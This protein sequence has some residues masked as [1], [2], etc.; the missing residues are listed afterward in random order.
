MFTFWKYF[1]AFAV[2]ILAILW[3]FQ[4][5]FLN[6]FYES[7]KIHEVTK[8]GDYL[9]SQY[10]NKDFESKVLNY[11]Q[12]KGLNIEVIDEEGT[13]I[14]PL[15]WLDVMINPKVIG[16]DAFDEYFAGVK[17]GDHPYRV[18]ITKL[19]HL[20]TPTIVYAGYLGTTAGTNYYIMI[21]TSPQ[22]VD[23][24][25]DVLK[26]LLIIVSILSLLLA[27]ALSYFISRRLSK[28][29]VEMSKTAKKLGS[30]DYSVNFKK[31]DYTEIDDLSNTLNYA[32]REITKTMEVRKDLIA[33]VSHDL[34]TPLTVI[35]SYGEM[36]R[37][38]SGN[39]EEM[40]NKHIDTI[41]NEADR[42]TMLV[43]DLLDISKI[44]SNLEEIKFDCID[45]KEVA[46]DVIDRFKIM[47]EKNN[48]KFNFIYSGNTHIFANKKR[49]EQVIYNLINNAIN[50]SKSEKDITIKVVGDL[51]VV[52]FD[53]IDKGI[54]IPKDKL[55]S[56]WERFYRVRNNHTRP[57]VGTGLGLYIVKNILEL[58]KFKYGVI[59]EEGVGSD[60]YFITKQCNTKVVS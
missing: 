54:G 29:L 40:R 58:H 33:N 60:F 14:Y 35:K 27:F 10:M 30:G 51:G 44:E 2:V 11:S 50:Y 45:L 12:K 57:T 34:K 18:S 31:G 37:D 53:C 3:L 43:N 13:L 16:S 48:Y 15:T 59:S 6:R 8:I 25:I 46:E 26:R 9:R 38:I 41:I 1:S 21:K 17:N 49:I 36:I 5:V 7:M 55:D 47:F 32:T 28:P 20:E 42:L 24:A 56:I 4:I 23:S 22:P 39:N 19:K 52:R